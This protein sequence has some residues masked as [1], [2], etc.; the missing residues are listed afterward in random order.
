[1]TRTRWR[2]IGTEARSWRKMLRGAMAI[3]G[4]L[5]VVGGGALHQVFEVSRV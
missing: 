4:K 5:K 2:D 3:G 1:M